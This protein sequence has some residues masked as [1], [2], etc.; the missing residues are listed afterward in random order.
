MVLQYGKDPLVKSVLRS[1]ENTQSILKELKDPKNTE[2][3]KD[4]LS[5]KYGVKYKS[6]DQQNYMNEAA[7]W[8]PH[9]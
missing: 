5:K 2:G 1:I 8:D 4:Q 3:T 6:K 7:L 9:S